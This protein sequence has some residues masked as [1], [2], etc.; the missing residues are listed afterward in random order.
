MVVSWLHRKTKET[1]PKYS[2][3]MRQPV[4]TTLKWLRKEFFVLYL[5]LFYPFVIVERER[6]MNGVPR[7][8]VQPR[9][10]ALFLE[11]ERQLNLASVNVRYRVGVGTV[12]LICHRL[13]ALG[14]SWQLLWNVR[15]GAK[16]GSHQPAMPGSPKPGLSLRSGEVPAFHYVV[17]W[18]VARA[19]LLPAALI[20]CYSSGGRRRKI[21][22]LCVQNSFWPFSVRFCINYA[23]FPINTES[24]KCGPQRRLPPSPE[25]SG[26]AP[27]L[28]G[29]S[30]TS[31]KRNNYISWQITVAEESVT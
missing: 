30:R 16:Q 12:W 21:W 27:A 31:W 29:E 22:G 19:S 7:L 15:M 8:P 17:P 25:N 2:R 9:D 4:A 13:Q 10:T 23:V 24:T 11:S 1:T 6:E 26:M 14:S 20:C 28:E 18:R 3:V 5:Q